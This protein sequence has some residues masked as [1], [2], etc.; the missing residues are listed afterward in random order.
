MLSRRT[1]RSLALATALL[2]VLVVAQPVAAEVDLGHS[3]TVGAYSLDDTNGTPGAR[4][5]YR[6]KP[7]WNLWQLRRMN[8]MPPNVRGVP[9]R[10]MM[11]VGWSFT[12][13]RRAHSAFSPDPGPWQN[14]YTSAVMTDM[15]N[16]QNDADFEMAGVRVYVPVE[17]GNDVVFAYRALVDVYWYRPND[18]VLGHARMRVQ[19]YRHLAGS[20]TDTEKGGCWDYHV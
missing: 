8:V 12:V 15:T 2:S 14:R 6:E 3:G 9:G 18:S 1:G 16:A 7:S 20:S 10:G 5:G 13:Q 17:P 11:K 19:W 4:C